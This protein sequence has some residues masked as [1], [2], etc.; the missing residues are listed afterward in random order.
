MLHIN[1]N[2]CRE[3]RFNWSY[4]VWL[5]SAF[6]LSDGVARTQAGAIRAGRKVAGS[7]VE[8]RDIGAAVN[9]RRIDIGETVGRTIGKTR[10]PKAP[11]TAERDA[12]RREAN[13]RADVAVAAAHA[14]LHPGR[15]RTITVPR[16]STVRIS[17][18]GG[19]SIHVS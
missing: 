14:R 1:I 19:V 13:A 4:S 7:E 8:H 15:S 11:G 6:K 9:I 5:D 3:G 18:R 2:V 10:Y 17:R 12:R 16:G